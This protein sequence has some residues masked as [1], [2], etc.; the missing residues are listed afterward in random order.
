[1]SQPCTNRR[2]MVNEVAPLPVALEW[3]GSRSLVP[4]G[5]VRLTS[6]KKFSVQCYMFQVSVAVDVFLVVLV[7]SF[8]W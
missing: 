3:P 7:C 8:S 1:M 5:G 4:F 2:A 6:D